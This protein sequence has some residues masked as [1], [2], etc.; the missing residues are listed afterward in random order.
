MSNEAVEGARWVASINGEVDGSGM[1]DSL[2]CHSMVLHDH[3][4][5]EKSA[6]RYKRP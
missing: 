2:G 3:P 1:G 6:R 5:V 4:G